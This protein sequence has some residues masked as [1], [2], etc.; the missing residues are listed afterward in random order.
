MS[1][2]AVKIAGPRFLAKDELFTNFD[3]REIL[4]SY[5]GVSREH[6]ESLPPGQN[7]YSQDGEL[8]FTEY[9]DKL[10]PRNSRWLIRKKII[11]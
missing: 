1:Y 4:Q 11:L 8:M 3:S 7:F 5:F 6:T 2:E 9:L 10:I